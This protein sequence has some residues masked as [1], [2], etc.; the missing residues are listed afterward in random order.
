MSLPIGSGCR[1]VHPR[2]CG[3]RG[4]VK[5]VS[6]RSTGSS[7]RVRGTLHQLEIPQLGQRFIPACAGNAFAVRRFPLR[8]TVHPRVCGERQTASLE[9]SSQIG[10]SPRVRGTRPAPPVGGV[11]GRFIPACAGNARRRRATGRRR[12]VH[13]RVCGERS[14]AHVAELAS[15]GSSP[16]VRGTP[17]AEFH[18]DD[19]GRFIPACA[20]NACRFPSPSRY[21]PVHPRVCGERAEPKI[22]RNHWNGSSPRVRGTPEAGRLVS[23]LQ[24][25]IPACAGNA[26]SRRSRT[27]RI[28]VHPRVCGERL[29]RVGDL[30]FGNGSSPR[31]RGTLRLPLRQRPLPRFIPACAGNATWAAA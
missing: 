4:S 14:K 31:V 10:S 7:P 23:A 2:V 11:G 3:E 13:P 16:R 1:A 29:P 12:A 5:G 17:A 25:F 24:R 21:R 6:P 27:T 15:R 20:G 28:A 22:F 8:S 26:I 19:E 9:F 18:V 30:L